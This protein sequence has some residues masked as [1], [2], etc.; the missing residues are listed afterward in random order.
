MS[1]LDE[2]SEGSKALTSTDAAELAN[3]LAVYLG[4][5][6]EEPSQQ[7]AAAR[8]IALT[9]ICLLKAEYGAGSARQ[10]IRTFVQDHLA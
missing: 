9:A 3:L 10:M 8:L 6:T 1:K 7:M 5:Y 2:P 4:K